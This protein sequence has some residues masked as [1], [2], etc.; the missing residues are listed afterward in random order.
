MQPDTS[1]LARYI[2]PLANQMVTTK[3]Y[4]EL[5][6]FVENRTTIFEKATQSIKQSLETV[7]INSQWQAK[8]YKKIGRI[9]IDFS[10]K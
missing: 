2:K 8:N 7:E 4:D 10:H 3:E 1:R 5:K 9:L 6:S